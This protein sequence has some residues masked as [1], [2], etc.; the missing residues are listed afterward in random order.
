M[1]LRIGRGEKLSQ[2]VESMNAV[3]EG[4]LTSRSAYN[5]AHQLQQDCPIIKGIYRIIHRKCFSCNFMISHS[6]SSLHVAPQAAVEDRAVNACVSL[7][8]W[9]KT[10]LRRA[11]TYLRSGPEA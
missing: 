10:F 2:I 5:L 1:G 8:G 9:C 7:Q 4:V 11:R 6:G 3:A